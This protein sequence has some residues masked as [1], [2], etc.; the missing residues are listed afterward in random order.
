MAADGSRTRSQKPK[1]S[2]AAYE[3]VLGAIPGAF[4]ICRV[5]ED[6]LVTEY[7]NPAIC[8]LIGLSR[9]EMMDTEPSVWLYHDDAGVFRSTFRRAASDCAAFTALCR[10]RR[11]ADGSI[12][13]IHASYTPQLAPDGTLRYFIRYTGVTEKRLQELE[14]DS[15]FNDIMQTMANAF[16]IVSLE[17]NGRCPVL[18]I[19]P[20]MS[21]LLNGTQEEILSIY[22]HDVLTGAHPEDLPHLTA[23]LQ[24]D[25]L[26]DND[27]SSVCRI[28]D[29][30]GKYIWVQII[31]R[32]VR[33][34]GRALLYCSF[35]DISEYLE[36]EALRREKEELEAHVSSA[37]RFLNCDM[38]TYDIE[39]RVVRQ[40][41][42]MPA[43]PNL[44]ASIEGGCESLLEALPLHPA[45][46]ETY[47]DVFRRIHVG[48]AVVIAEF[49]I[50]ENYAHLH[51]GWVRQ[52][53]T[54]KKDA[55]GEP[56]EAWGVAV[57]V[58]EEKRAREKYE[59]EPCR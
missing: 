39:A 24:E 14:Q 18:Y 1:R 43:F 27:S 16:A 21:H 59:N 55:T 48:E 44:P 20:A 17:P 12:A 51:A 19:N 3:A 2:A 5:T 11:R 49:R 45:D 29:C 54:V 23:Q 28:K 56:L 40:F 42:K 53:Y 25:I 4:S 26:A 33:T 13:R 57:D 41:K 10:T 22:K 7:A 9:T 37:A 47:R 31:S 46:M 6:A 8:A 58:N 15:R 38:W 52:I 35:T 34:A 32:C 50:T 30:K 36:K